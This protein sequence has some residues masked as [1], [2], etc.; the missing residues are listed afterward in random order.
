MER[1]PFWILVN[2]GTDL[3]NTEKQLNRED[4]V[5]P[6]FFNLYRLPCTGNN[7]NSRE[8]VQL[9]VCGSTTYLW[10]N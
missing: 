7:L 5:H 9:R 8:V 1:V 4:I 3:M 2:L 6:L 10:F